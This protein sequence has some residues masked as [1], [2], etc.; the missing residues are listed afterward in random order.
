V[1]AA[2]VAGA[3]TFSLGVQYLSLFAQTRS[4]SDLAGCLISGA[5]AAVAIILAAW[6]IRAAGDRKEVRQ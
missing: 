5:G 4:A 1:L 6:T 3:A 2:T